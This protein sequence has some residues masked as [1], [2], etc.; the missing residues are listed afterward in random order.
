M[1][2]LKLFIPLIIFIVLAG[3]F[4]RGLSLDPTVVPSALIDK[5]FPEF[6]LPRL[7][8]EEQMTTKAD[9]LGEMT[10]VNIWATWCVSCRVEHPYLNRLAQAGVRIVGINYKDESVAARQWLHEL[11]NPYRW[12]IVD[13]AGSLGIDLGVTGAPETYVIDRQGVVRY[14]HVGVVDQQVWDE[15]LQPFFQQLSPK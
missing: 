3:F 10:L 6:T 11:G 9:L 12:N 8:D 1:N 13:Q 7:D 14:R 5:H 15:R 4:F 2:R